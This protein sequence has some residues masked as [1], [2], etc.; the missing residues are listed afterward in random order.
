MD[1]SWRNY[2]SSWGTRGYPLMRLVREKLPTSGVIMVTHQ[3]V[4]GTWPMIF[5]TLARFYKNNKALLYGDINNWSE[6]LFL[7]SFLWRWCGAGRRWQKHVHAFF[8]E[9][10]VYAPVPVPVNGNTHYTRKAS[11]VYRPGMAISAIC[12][13]PTCGTHGFN[14]KYLV[15][16]GRYSPE[17]I[18]IHGASPYQ[19][20]YL[21]D[22]IVQLITWT[23]RMSPMPVVQPI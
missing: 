23:Q 15:E 3:P 4:S 14:A 10:T 20:A 9:M 1:I 7:A 5:V 8:W 12:W 2:L 22:G 17:K 21:I 11:S 6:F 18:S 19:N 13:E 16:P